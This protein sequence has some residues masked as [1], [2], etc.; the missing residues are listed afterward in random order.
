MSWTQSERDAIVNRYHE[1]VQQMGDAQFAVNT[2][3]GES[4]Q[5]VNQHIG[6]LSTEI[7]E[8]V[9]AYKKGLPQ[10]ALS[11][12]PITGRP[13]RHTFD[14]CDLRGLWWR[15]ENPARPRFE[16]EAGSTFVALT[17]AVLLAKPVEY[18]MFVVRPGPGAPFVIPELLKRP[19]VRA[20]LSCFAVGQHTAFAI[21]YFSTEPLPLD[22][23]PT[24][25]GTEV[26]DLN[27][28]Y[29]WD[30]YLSDDHRRYDFN[31]GP[32]IDQGKL[33]WTLPGDATLRLRSD[34]VGCPYL[35]VD[36]PRRIQY[37][38]VGEVRESSL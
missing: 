38:S 10:Q 31:I 6:M 11:R 34:S 19:S 13:M 36:G 17:G 21:A 4:R 37:V 15:G 16:L 29:R 12:C 35:L 9:E 14:A 20:T 23:K 26:P 3:T 32:W 27:P 7:Y 1:A 30:D 33:A 22:A 24:I 8:L 25:W 5:I 18:T 28:N 2:L